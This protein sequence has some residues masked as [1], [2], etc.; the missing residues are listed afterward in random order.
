MFLRI[1]LL[2]ISMGWASQL[3]SVVSFQVSWGLFSLEWLLLRLL[4]LGP[5][6]LSSSSG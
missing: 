3:M 1:I 6:V 2:V 5:C 4:I